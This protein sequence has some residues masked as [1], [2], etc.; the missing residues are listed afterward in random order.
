MRRQRGDRW[1]WLAHERVGTWWRVWGMLQDAL[2]PRIPGAVF[3]Q[4]DAGAACLK[5]V[6]ER[7]RRRTLPPLP[8]AALNLL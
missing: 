3:W 1:G 2:A 4:E 6:A 5:V 8:L 7:P